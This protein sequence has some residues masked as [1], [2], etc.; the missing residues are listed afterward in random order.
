MDTQA[1]LHLC[2]LHALKSGFLA[3]RPILFWCGSGWGWHV[4]QGDWMLSLKNPLL[5][6]NQICGEGGIG[7]LCGKCADLDQLAS[8]DLCRVQWLQW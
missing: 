6:F 4:D 2:C 8:I 7:Y 3:S 5:G 1:G